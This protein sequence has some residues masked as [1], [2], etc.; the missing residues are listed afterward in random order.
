[1]KSPGS[2]GLSQLQLTPRQALKQRQANPTTP[3]WG[4]LALRITGH[5]FSLVHG[6]EKSNIV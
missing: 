2:D 6:R 4:A 1:M 3:V 5:A